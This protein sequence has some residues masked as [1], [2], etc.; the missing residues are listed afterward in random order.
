MRSIPRI[1]SHFAEVPERHLQCRRLVH[2]GLRQQI[3]HELFDILVNGG[4]VSRIEGHP[5]DSHRLGK[6]PVTI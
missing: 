4:R 3:D 6:I 2:A 1:L 5:I